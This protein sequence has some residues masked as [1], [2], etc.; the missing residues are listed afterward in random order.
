MICRA[1][2]SPAINAAN[3]A[4]AIEVN[5]RY[6]SEV[7]MFHIDDTTQARRLPWVRQAERLPYN[8]LNQ[9]AAE[10]PVHDVQRPFVDVERGFSHG[11]A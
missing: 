1:G 7:S 5:R 11:F 4:Q 6:L 10:L 2:A 3:C 9:R 8:F